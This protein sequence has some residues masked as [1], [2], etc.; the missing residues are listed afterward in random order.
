MD[1]SP[2][3][4]EIGTLSERMEEGLLELVHGDIDLEIDNH[5]GAFERFIVNGQRG[6]EWT[7]RIWRR[8]RFRR[9]P[10][11]LL[12]AGVLDLPASVHYNRRTKTANVQAF[13][14]SK[15]LESH[16][17]EVVKRNVVGRTGTVVAASDSVSVSDTTD[18]LPG[19][20]ITLT[21]E[22]ESVAETQT[23][24]AIVAT[25]T[26]G[27]IRTVEVWDND[28]TDA[29][30]TLDTP[31]H[32][33]ETVKELAALL[34]QA[35]GL[36]HYDIQV[37]QDISETPLAT[38][39]NAIGLPLE[40]LRSVTVQGGDVSV[41]GQ[42]SG[43]QH[44]DSPTDPFS[45]VDAVIDAQI[46]WRPYLLSEPGTI[47]RV[48][49]GVGAVDDVGLY[50]ADHAAG[51]Y[52][53]LIK[54]PLGP[55]N[56]ST[57]ELH[58]NGVNIQQVDGYTAGSGNAFWASRSLDLDVVNGEAWCSFKRGDGSLERTVIVPIPG[59][60]SAT[61]Y[62]DAFGRLRFCRALSRMFRLG[63]SLEIHTIGSGK[64]QERAV[65]PPSG[66]NAWTLRHCDDFVFGVYRNGFTLGC[67]VWS[68]TLW[69]ELARFTLATGNYDAFT[70]IFDETDGDQV[71]LVLL[72]LGP[73]GPL[74]YVISREFA[75]VIPY[76][77]FGGMSVS[78]GLRQLALVSMA[79]VSV[80][81]YRTGQLIGRNTFPTF[82]E[83]H[84]LGVPLE[85]TSSP[86]SEDY[87]TSVR[88]T[89]KDAAGD[90]IVKLAG[91]TG[92][93]SAR[94]ELE[95]PMITTESLAAGIAQNY[96]NLLSSMF[97]AGEEAVEIR[98]TGRLVR[99]LN[100][101]TLDAVPFRVLEAE[102]EIDD[103]R[104]QLRLLRVS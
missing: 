76:A 47:V 66:L 93:S 60:G 35:A 3:L 32:R 91:A 12:F 39:G 89:G 5:D 78:A 34:F 77:D 11:E 88:V 61:T 4:S 59:G 72:D 99:P 81:R 83:E 96:S 102:T 80:D 52:Y 21:G 15:L 28:F 71:G 38:V 85:Q 1:L 23:I 65:V 30:L 98:E 19:D 16:S 79:T 95:S 73:L 14:Y 62:N 44:A 103:R 37:D 8:V 57:L 84:D 24:E 36:T 56:P 42:L 94:L 49:T 10:W 17:A 48:P 45:D 92:D 2:R 40:T 31:Y 7:V 27:T 67:V 86:V 68:A 53:R 29:S 70:T 100:R 69:T 43:T 74:Y 55:A 33:N 25:G 87:R 101:A 9:Q 63:A 22:D 20:E 90:D 54:N 41:V 82:T 97:A 64:V 51:D 6:E 75:G 13:T 50:A 26:P 18:L 58:R 104:Q 46:D